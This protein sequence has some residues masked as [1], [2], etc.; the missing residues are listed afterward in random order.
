MRSLEG[1]EELEAETDT[2]F[3]T[4]CNSGAPH[5]GATLHLCSDVPKNKNKNKTTQ[6]TSLGE[7]AL[8]MRFLT[9]VIGECT[10]GGRSVLER[11]SASS[12]G[13][14]FRVREGAVAAG[15]SHS[16]G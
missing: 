5:W 11:P 16:S 12:L 14:T 1:T 2:N 6:R 4:H 13:A 15:G 3:L 9:H 10:H 7:H 8:D